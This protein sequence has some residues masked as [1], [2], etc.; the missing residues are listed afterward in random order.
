MLVERKVCASTIDTGL[1]QTPLFFAVRSEPESGGLECPSFLIQHS[2]NADHVD[3]LGQTPLFYAA[4]R[5]SPECVEALI[6]ARAVVDT[7]D[8]SGKRATFF[9]AK[10]G[11]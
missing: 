8:S 2:C 10:Q 7:A 4:K 9:A 5:E 3:V 11:S 1:Q 6:G